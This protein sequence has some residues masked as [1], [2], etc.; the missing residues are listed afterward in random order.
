MSCKALELK[1]YNVQMLIILLKLRL[2]IKLKINMK[3]H[4]VRELSRICFS[5]YSQIYLYNENS[6][7]RLY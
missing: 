5:S 2:K 7:I 4:F 1:E 6:F 3:T